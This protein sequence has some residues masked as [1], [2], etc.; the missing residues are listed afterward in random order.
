MTEE[1]LLKVTVGKPP[2][3]LNAPITLVE[4]DP[5]WPKL[6]IREA[7]RISKI[8]GPKAFQIEHVGSTAIPGIVAKPIIDIDLVVANSADEQSYIPDLEAAGYTLRIREPDWHEH[9]LLKGPDTNINLHVFSQGS[10]E[11]ERNLVFRDWLR[12]HPEDKILYASTKQELAKQN[13]KYV[14]GYADAKSK[15]VETII[16]RARASSSR[17]HSPSFQPETP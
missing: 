12:T 17:R 8:L 3:E 7:Q 1:Q 9:R 11:V 13:W 4:Y 5:N 14:Q 6:F 10:S 16:A 2:Q 15:V